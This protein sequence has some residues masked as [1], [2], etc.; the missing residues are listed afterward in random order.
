MKKLLT[1]AVAGVFL[2]VGFAATAD[3][4]VKKPGYQKKMPKVPK[5][6]LH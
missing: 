5:K 2:A 6:S 1:L 3:A 4:Q